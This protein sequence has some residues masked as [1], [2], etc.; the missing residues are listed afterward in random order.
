MYWGE[1]IEK[2]DGDGDKW[3]GYENPKLDIET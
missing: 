1:Q 2:M 3:R